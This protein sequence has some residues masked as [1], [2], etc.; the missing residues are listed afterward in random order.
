MGIHDFDLA[1]YLRAH[2][3]G[4]RPS[5]SP[6]EW[7]MPCPGCGGREHLYVNV[8]KR[9]ANCFR[10]GWAPGLIDLLA[11]L[12][13]RPREEISE[14]L[15][16]TD[17]RASIPGL[18]NLRARV[19]A[20]GARRVRATTSPPE[21][22]YPDGYL[23]LA[24]RQ[25]LDAERALAP[26]RA[27]LVRRRVPLDRVSR[28]AIGCALVGR[29]AG[30]VILPVHLDG[31]L[32]TFQARDITG[33][34]RAKYLGPAGTPL[35]ETLFNLDHARQHA[36]IILCEGIV[37]AICTGTD[38]VASFGKTL[39]P[40]QVALLVRAGRPVIVLYD[41]AKPETQAL[42]AAREAMEAARRLHRAGVEVSVGR[43]PWGD[44]ADHPLEEVRRAVDEAGPFALAQLSLRS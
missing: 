22:P 43:L 42:D 9:C 32:V 27:Y 21:I 18:E 12:E 39:K 4:G 16:A 40:A 1:G 36:R 28:H 8:E 5:A 7:V 37:S 35:G 33:R 6:A 17:Q 23:P 10:C 44:P 26:F 3:R 14:R 41:A 38:A 20:A 29:Y 34:A 13:R 30:R 11:Q 15:A 2:A 24:G 25:T 19:L 31:R